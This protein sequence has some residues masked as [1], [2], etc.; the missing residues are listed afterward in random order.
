MGR[1]TAYQVLQAAAVHVVQQ[2]LAVLMVTLMA[3]ASGAVTDC[4]SPT[5][6]MRGATGA[7]AASMTKPRGE[8]VAA[9]AG[10]KQVLLLAR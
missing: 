1:G 9:A 10:R 5:V 3:L 6:T 2:V 7:A 4:K 8:I